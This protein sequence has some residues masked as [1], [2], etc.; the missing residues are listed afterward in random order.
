MPV[1]NGYQ[2]GTAN[3]GFYQNQLQGLISNPSSFS[4]TPGYQFALNQSL[5]A[6]NHQNS[7]IRGSGNALA[8]LTDRAG[9]MASQ[10]YGDYLKTLGGLTG[11]EQNYDLGLAGANNT[12]Q[13]NANQ[14]SLGQQQNANTLALGQ[15]NIAN[16]AQRNANDFSLGS[17][18]AANNFTLG[19]QSNANNAQR[20]WWDYSLGN[21]QNQNQYNLGMFNANTNRAVGQTD[22]SA[23][24]LNAMTNWQRLGYQVNPAQRTSGVPGTTGGSWGGI[25]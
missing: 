20:N 21:Q 9:G 12:A 10:N 14:F 5:D 15:G 7:A 6:L 2:T 11:Q 19:Q 8:A 16:N 24:Y 23:N 13:S 1:G 25:G 18:N 3:P 22:S 4:G 17:T